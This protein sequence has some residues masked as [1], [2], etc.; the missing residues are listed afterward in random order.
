VNKLMKH[1]TSRMLFSYWDALRGERAAPDRGEIEPGAIRHILADTF[2]LEVEDN[3]RAEFRLAGT[4]LC[5]FFGHELKNH[6]LAE[7]WSSSSRHEAAKLID[8][9][10]DETA[11][12]VVGLNGTTASGLS[13]DL[14]M[15]LLPLRHR[16]KTHS[17][18]LGA[19]S[20][21]TLPAWLGIDHLVTLKTVSLRVIWPTRRLS[22]DTP[23]TEPALE[24]RRQFVVHR[25]GRG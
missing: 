2:I 16:G 24:R 18:M 11:G 23:D 4:R 9:V 21:L 12:L 1:A 5:A 17:R 3:R 7:F 14:E 15:M 25:G 22:L 8:I 13:L 6:S 19:L 20:S 10:I